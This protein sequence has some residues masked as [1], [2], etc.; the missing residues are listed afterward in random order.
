MLAR[1]QDELS[2]G[3]ENDPALADGSVCLYLPS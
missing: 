2:K 1:K 3:V